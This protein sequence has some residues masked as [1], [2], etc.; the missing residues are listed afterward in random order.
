MD[1]KGLNRYI[2]SAVEDTYMPLWQ[3]FMILPLLA[4]MFVVVSTT[5]V[6]MKLFLKHSSMMFTIISILLSIVGQAMAITDIHFSRRKKEHLGSKLGH[7][8]LFLCAMILQIASRLLT[9]CVFGMSVFPSNPFTPLIL[10]GMIFVHI[11]VVFILQDIT[12]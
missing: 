12:S 4:E 7:K 9:I 10:T 11:I 5:E 3:T 2:S 8:C 6:T 1:L